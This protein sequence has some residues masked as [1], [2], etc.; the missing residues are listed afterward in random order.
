MTAIT[1]RCPVCGQSFTTTAHQRP[2]RRYCCTRCRKIAW[3]RRRPRSRPSPVPRPGDLAQTVPRP[4][5]GAHVA[6]GGEQTL[7][8]HCP[9]CAQP[10]AVITLLV[11]PAAAQVP[12]PTAQAR[13]GY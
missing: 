10:V 3:R 6:A 2:P 13:H 7:P 1:G 12:T 4:A 8:A 5:D 9:H 11:V